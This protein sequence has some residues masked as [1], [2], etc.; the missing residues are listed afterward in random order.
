MQ[1]YVCAQ[2]HSE[3]YFEPETTRVIF[4]WDKGL[5]AAP[6]WQYYET[7]PAGFD[8]DFTHTLSGVRLL[9]AQH[10]NYE[11]FSGGVH[12]QANVTCADC[13]LPSVTIDGKT[14]RSHQITSPLLT[15]KESCMTCHKGKTEDCSL[16]RLK[17]DR[18]RCTLPRRGLDRP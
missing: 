1:T 16:H 12:G 13:H 9:K 11:E 4:P 3:Y 14:I 17:R 6:A 5:G 18:T 15:I 8:G 7:K 2:C 10:P